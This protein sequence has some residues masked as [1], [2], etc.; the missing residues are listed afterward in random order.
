MK[1]YY[2]YQITFTDT[3]HIYF[4][5]RTSK[6]PPEDDTGYMGSP[7]TYKQYWIDFTPVKT[8][9]F[10]GFSSR[11]EAVKYEA[12]LIRNQWK[13]NKS[14][15]LNDS[16]P[17]KNFYCEWKSSWNKGRTGDV[18]YWRDKERPADTRQKISK[19][20][21]GVPRHDLSKEYAAISPQGNVHIFLNAK[22][23]CRDNR[24]LGFTPSRISA[25]AKEWD[26]SHKGWQFFY[27]EDYE[28]LNGI[29]PETINYQVIKEYVGISPQGEIH[30]FASANK[31]ARDN[32]QWKLKHQSISACA[33]KEQKQHKGWQFF[34]KE[35]YENLNGTIP[36]VVDR[37]TLVYIGISPSGDIHK[38]KIA[39]EFIK[40]NPQ[41]NLTDSGISNCL[42]GRNPHHKGWRFFYEHDYEIIK[43]SIPVVV[44]GLVKKYIA[45]SPTGDR[46]T[47]DNAAQF[48]REHPQWKISRSGISQCLNGKLNHYKGWKFSYADESD[49]A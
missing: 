7:V 38:F 46:Y 6:C 49:I 5:S 1:Y 35:D 29:V 12:E 43:D 48:C 21:K 4:G 44:T 3:P 11:D 45:V 33:K 23:F 37:S 20:L 34:Y 41:Y 18:G 10:T 13:L 15:S 42:S 32:S 30:T 24:E 2:C 22:Q 39:A 14:L 17:G 25:C 31:F 27:K 28:A 47:F 40:N 9:L 36:C 26:K 16:I 8:I 19:K